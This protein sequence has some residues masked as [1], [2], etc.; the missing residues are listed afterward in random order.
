MQTSLAVEQKDMAI[1][2][3]LQTRYIKGNKINRGW[4]A[5]DQKATDHSTDH[6]IALT[7]KNLI[8]AYVFTKN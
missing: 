2:N 4:I 7:G 8:N 6:I 3:C 5:L 1:K